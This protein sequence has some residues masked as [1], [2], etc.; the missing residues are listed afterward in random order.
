MSPP[1]AAQPGQP[2]YFA[3]CGSKV[4]PTTVL[5][6]RQ[7]LQL[8]HF[9]YHLPPALIAHHPTPER[10]GS[11]LC[12][13]HADGSVSDHI[14]RDLSTILPAGS[15]LVLNESQTFK[16]R[17]LHTLPAGKVIEILLFEPP[18]FA[19]DGLHCLGPKQQLLR[20]GA[21]TLADG[22]DVEFFCP[23][24]G[25]LKVRFK[26]TARYHST[27]QLHTWLAQHGQVP[28]PPYI[29]R[30][31][32]GAD[33]QRYQTIYAKQDMAGSAAAP[34]AGLHL[35]Q[36]MFKALAERNIQCAFV[37]LNISGGTFLPVRQAI[38]TEHPMHAESFY[39]PRATLSTM[40]AYA[41]A[42]R[43]IIMVGTTTL[44]AIEALGQLGH[45]QMDTALTFTDHWHRTNLF[46]HPHT[47][48]STYRPWLGQGMITN[49]HA[50]ESTL[51]MLVAALV[52]YAR[53]CKLYDHALR[54]KYRFLSYGD[55]SLLWW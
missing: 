23:D 2:Y 7:P 24:E 39:V 29:K 15:L 19:H 30:A 3:D 42:G 12:Q 54:S 9:Q 17:I 48:R 26:P 25:N 51:L 50:S 10:D 21:I 52:G 1:A 14:F 4:F 28:L 45:Y 32:T 20:L 5:Y 6:G 18:H 34:T 55:A 35:T 36:G 16:A 11:R 13:L 41:Q 38:L 22:V 53:A 27:Q 31:A 44:R 46:I 8:Q 37:R 49:F 33:N 47:A 43:P 40:G